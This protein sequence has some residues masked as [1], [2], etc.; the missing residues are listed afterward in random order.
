MKRMLDLPEKPIKICDERCDR[1]SLETRWRYLNSP[2]GQADAKADL[3]FDW[4]LRRLRDYETC[5][6][7]CVR[8]E[9]TGHQ[10]QL[11]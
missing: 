9:E 6:L 11:L 7:Q 1:Q 2:R 10:Q 8:D 4:W 5:Y 3:K